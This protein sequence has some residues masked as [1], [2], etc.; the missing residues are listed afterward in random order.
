MDE[1]G[2]EIVPPKYEEIENFEEG[3][4][5]VKLNAK[6]GLIDK[7]DREV[8][9]PKYDEIEVSGE[10]LGTFLTALVQI[11]QEG[12]KVLSKDVARVRLGKKWGLINT[13]G[14]EFVPPK[15]SEMKEF[16]DGMAG[17]KVGLL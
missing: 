7:T 4:A 10:D 3:L 15:Y 1:A 14:R 6:W 16:Q 12:K 11:V 13:A 9:P 5:R 2:R 17:A 8:I